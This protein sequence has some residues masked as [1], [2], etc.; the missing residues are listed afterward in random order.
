MELLPPS[1]R[2]GDDGKG[3]HGEIDGHCQPLDHVAFPTRHESWS[4]DASGTHHSRISCGFD[5]LG[6]S[7]CGESKSLRSHEP[8]H[9]CFAQAHTE[10]LR[11]C[12]GFDADAWVDGE[13]G[14]SAG[15]S[16]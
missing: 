12:N 3:I 4:S 16:W 14:A 10:T 6:S 5:P 9:G 8:T 7:R 2:W 11:G 15:Q 13:W 1:R